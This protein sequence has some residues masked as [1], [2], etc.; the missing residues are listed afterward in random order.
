MIYSYQNEK[1]KIAFNSKFDEN[2]NIV[3][4]IKYLFLMN[5]V[6]SFIGVNKMMHFEENNITV[7]QYLDLRTQVNWKTLSPQQAQKALDN[8]LY[9]LA[10][11][12]DG[13]LVGMGRLIGDGAV[14]CYIQDLIVI[15]DIQ[16]H[17]IG[18][19]L[20]DRL[21]TYAAS[22]GFPGTT[23]MLDLMCAKGREL[24][25][26]KHGFMQRPTKDLGPGM[27]QYLNL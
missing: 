25:Y 5:P 17:G 3:S 6:I 19:M 21:I 14:I 11:Y 7:D 15:P 4:L 23:M 10:A 18:S 20:M 26:Q 8:S 2:I 16:A 9:V 1:K 24:F 27:I 13:T 12:H 22:L